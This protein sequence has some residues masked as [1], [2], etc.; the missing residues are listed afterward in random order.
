MIVGNQDQRN[1]HKKSHSRLLKYICISLI[2]VY[3]YSVCV[4]CVNVMSCDLP[5]KPDISSI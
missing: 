3:V 2:G 1:N 4:R 5:G